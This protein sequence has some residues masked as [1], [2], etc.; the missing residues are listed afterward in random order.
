MAAVIPLGA[1]DLLEPLG[2]GGM[3]EVWRGVHRGEGLPVA[4]KVITAE[5]GQSPEAR[6]LFQHEARAVAAL[7]HPGIVAVFD[8]GT[9]PEPAARGSGG[10]LVAGSPFL[11]MEYAS[12]GTLRDRTVASWD[13]AH[14]VLV[15]LLDAL[16]H[17]H[18]RGVVH[19]DLKASNV[20]VR[21]GADARSGLA[22]A[23][24]GIAWV[25]GGDDAA[26]GMGS[27][28]TMAP[29]Q[30]RGDGRWF[31]PWTDLY[32]LGVV[33]WRLVTGEHPF[34]GVT[35]AALARAHLAQPLRP[36][37]PRFAVPPRLEAWL[38]T[39]LDKSPAHRFQCAADA[40]H[41]LA[42][43]GSAS[44]PGHTVAVPAALDA[45]TATLPEWAIPEVA[46]PQISEP[47]ER[48]TR[49]PCPTSWRTSASPPPRQWLAV[50]QGLLAHRTVPLIG[51]ENEREALWA[52]FR[53]VVDSQDAAA[54]AL[55]GPAGVGTTRLATWLATRATEVGAA[56]WIDARDGL[57][58][59]LARALRAEGLSGAELVDWLGGRLAGAEI[60]DL[61]EVAELLA[62][63]SGVAEGVRVTLRRAP[64]RH[65][66][67]RS[68]LRR[69]CGE[70]AVVVVLDEHA[71]GPAFARSCAGEAGLPV[72]VVLT[73]SDTG[74]A[75]IGVPPF[76]DEACRAVVEAALGVDPA[77]ARHLAHRAAGNPS[78]A[79]AVL[80]HWV[81][82][83]AL[84]PG[85][86][87]L[88]HR[89]D[90]E[91]PDDL[92]AAWAAEV[93]ALL[94]RVPTGRLAL[95]LAATLGQ[96]VAASE[97]AAAC[98]LARA[99]RAEDVREALFARRL[100]VRTRDGWAFVH[101]MVHEAVL[102]G[103]SE[104]A[105]RHA[106]C[107]EVLADQPGS[108]G[109]LGRH[110]LGAGRP[111]AAVG[112]L[113]DAVD[114]PG[115][116][117]LDM[118]ILLE[119]R[120]RALEQAGV[121]ERD[122]AW[123][124]GWVRLSELFRQLGHTEQASQWAERAIRGYRDHGWPASIGARALRCQGRLSRRRGAL[125]DA[126]QELA[127]ATA[128]ARGVGDALLLGEVRFDQALVEMERG[129]LD[130]AEAHLRASLAHMEDAGHHGGRGNALRGL[131]SV[132]KQRG[133]LAGAAGWLARAR[134]A[135]RASGARL[136]AA[137]TVISEG[138]LARLGGRLEEAEERYIEAAR[139]LRQLGS[140]DE[141]VARLNLG[142]VLSAQ[143]RWDEAAAHLRACATAR[144]VPRVM[145]G[146]IHAFLLPCLA[147]LGDTEGYDEALATAEA[148]LEDVGNADVDVA[149]A[150]EEAAKTWRTAGDASRAERA[151]IL[152]ASQ[153]AKLGR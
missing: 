120:E 73:G 141:I 37:A 75:E 79:L 131:Y 54:I 105:Q 5:R 11:V 31:G 59:G 112:P 84:V 2:R 58:A 4:V 42:G 68:L 116:E 133:D 150:A 12:G 66:A 87:G 153:W 101:G 137:G 111:S 110:L 140:A 95:E 109:R 124:A 129:A 76:S 39:L 128:L 86:T 92:H 132:A 6:Q 88:Q 104:L 30:L 28:A 83:G 8:L 126:A 60:E 119:L 100:A 35:G 130:P 89:A 55:H 80:R 108:A 27:V 16:A 97:W 85:P 145:R 138:E 57:R 143:R 32:A 52:A 7:D 78:F 13:E 118:R 67:A 22:L 117:L 106:V 45:P 3:G 63:G 142:L 43:L 70:R 48:W 23:D 115:L 107:A 41:A 113:L 9:V 99:Q 134:E 122:P 20:L 50:G 93:H 44:L 26:S 90:V 65:A 82:V 46:A 64:E 139:Q 17:A 1:F 149:R 10:R 102:A 38:A 25:L 114:A 127:E 136:G 103:C 29:E 33:A 24:F 121:P 77:T 148:L 81:A 19:R 14:P 94:D 146:P 47:V 125:E 151:E 15:A 98:R 61:L 71:E 74:V 152:A 53:G 49:P 56:I 123:G 40:A 135:Y 144:R 147:A 69:L 62:P 96:R 51:R 91:L 21:A 36:L 18:A 72:L 34:P